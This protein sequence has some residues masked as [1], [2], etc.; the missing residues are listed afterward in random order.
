MG[1][2]GHECEAGGVMGTSTKTVQRRVDRAMVMLWKE[3]EHVR[4][5]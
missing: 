4:A 3:L 1:R 2:K 5:S